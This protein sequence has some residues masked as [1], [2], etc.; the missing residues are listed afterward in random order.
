MKLDLRLPTIVVTGAWN[1]K[2]F[3]PQWIS[4]HLFG[5]DEGVNV[6]I[7][8]IVVAT[9]NQQPTT[10]TYI[11]HVGLRASESRV[12][13]F[14]DQLEADNFTLLERVAKN[15]ISILQHTP[16]GALGVN[17]NF[18]EEEP[19]DDL[20]DKLKSPDGLERKFAIKAQSFKATIG[21]EEHQDLNLSREISD[22][23]VKINFNYHF[24]PLRLDIADGILDDCVSNSL[25]KTREYLD[26]LYGLEEFELIIFARNAAGAT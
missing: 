17:F 9:D 6:N 8:Q 13:L 25:V 18:I 1:P 14:M 21:L 10:I 22:G 11:D 24:S 20:I 26:Q 7:E 5:Y 19:E 2:I 15:T 16:L 4:K 12:E 23:L 3:S